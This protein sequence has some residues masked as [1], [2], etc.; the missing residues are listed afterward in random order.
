M[1]YLLSD[2]QD[3]NKDL[4]VHIFQRSLN[5]TILQKA[6]TSLRLLSLL[7]PENE[8]RISVGH[9]H[10]SSLKEPKVSL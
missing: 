8:E 7:H 4:D 2:E 6:V 5:T 9:M 10:H 1:K 3:Q